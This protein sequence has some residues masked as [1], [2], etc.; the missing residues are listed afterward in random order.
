VCVYQ[1]FYDV[2][3]QLECKFQVVAC[4]LRLLACS[5]ALARL[6]HRKAAFAKEIDGEEKNEGCRMM[7]D[8]HQ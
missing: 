4:C 7:T 8:V 5:L 2:V 6:L 1:W 3:L